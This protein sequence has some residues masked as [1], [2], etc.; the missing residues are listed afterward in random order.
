MHYRV[1]AATRRRSKIK[2]PVQ[3]GI[4]LLCIVLFC[5]KQE[6]WEEKDKK[7]DG[8]KSKKRETFFRDR[9]FADSIQYN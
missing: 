8:K 3:S 1:K 9:D 5:F 7:K 4:S 6:F 2:D